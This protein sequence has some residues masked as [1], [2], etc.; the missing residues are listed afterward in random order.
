MVT[1]LGREIPNQLHELT[2]Q[3]F[4][5]ITSIHANTELDAIDKHL[6]TFELLGVP[7]IEF[8]D[9]QIEEF[10]EYVK[11]FNN[12]SG[13]PELIN[14]FEHDGYTYIAFEDE[15]K[16]SV[17]DTKSIEKIMNS[18]HKGYISEMLAVLFKRSDLTKV[19]H[20]SDAHIKLK[21]KI[22]REMK[23]EIAVPYLVEIGQ[24]LSKQMPKN[25]ATEIME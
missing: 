2:V 9:V 24:K 14:K 12:L 16:L 7:T 10:K 5:T 1:I 13:K 8:D 6:Q 19:E 20:Y 15:F 3:Q 23:A 25:E 21:S 4:E 22:I 18:R 11:E 17:K